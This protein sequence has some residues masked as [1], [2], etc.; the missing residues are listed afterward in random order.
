M[1]SSSL[2]QKMPAREVETFEKLRINCPSDL[3]R[4]QLWSACPE[5]EINFVI[6]K[7]SRFN[8]LQVTDGEPACR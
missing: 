1:V 3:S 4:S 2:C 7:H 8:M 6:R 5:S